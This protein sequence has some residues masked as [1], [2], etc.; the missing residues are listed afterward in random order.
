MRKLSAVI[1][2]G[3][4]LRCFTSV[5]FAEEDKNIF[6]DWYA[7]VFAASY[8]MP[9]IL[10]SIESDNHPKSIN[11]FS[12]GL[13]IGHSFNKNYSLGIEFF[14]SEVSG[15][16]PWGDDSK[17]R[18]YRVDGTV[19]GKVSV[20]VFGIGIDATRRFFLTDRVLIYARLGPFGIGYLNGDANVIF[21][22][23]SID[24]PDNYI[25]EPGYEKFHRLIPII[26]VGT[27]VEWRITDSVSISAGPYWNTGFGGEGSVVW[28]FDF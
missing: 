16:G 28:R 22:G 15:S 27:G 23:H 1:F 5:A 7:E 3:L 21:R 9:G 6:P 25:E 2:A 12:A 24:F 8:S 13:R 19:N 17:M 14:H 18:S 26:G 10:L 11:G 4:L 20:D